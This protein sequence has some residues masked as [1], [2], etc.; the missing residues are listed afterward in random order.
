MF[1]YL[2]SW[3]NNHLTIN[4]NEP[5]ARL[6]T[7]NGSA[8]Y[9]SGKEFRAFYE[10]SIP[11][12]GRLVIKFQVLSDITLVLSSISIDDGGVIF[13]AYSGGVESGVFEPVFT[14]PTN[15]TSTVINEASNLSISVGG[16]VD[17]TGLTPNDVVRIKAGQNK[18]S[19][20]DS[21]DNNLRG[22]PA[23][24]YYATIETL[25]SVNSSSSGTISWRWHNS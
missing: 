8:A 18:Q 5:S 23:G 3:F 7:E 24:T 25:D 19:T 17:V 1:E 11:N 2:T 16:E 4:P 21:S 15:N 13:K 14:A 9:Q 22:F 20:V 6:K 12:S 10:L